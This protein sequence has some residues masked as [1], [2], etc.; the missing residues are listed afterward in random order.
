M[1]LKGKLGPY[2]SKIRNE[3]GEY[4]ILQIFEKTLDTSHPDQGEIPIE[5]LGFGEISI[6]FEI[7][8]E[9]LRG[10][11]FKRLPLFETE[12][13]VQRHIAAYKQ[14]REIL[15][16][17]IGLTIPPQ[18]TAWVYMDEDK[19]KIALYCIQDKIDPS[20]VINKKLSEISFPELQPILKRI[21]L[22]LKKVWQFNRENTE[23]LEVALDAQISNWAIIDQ[24]ERSSTEGFNNQET[25]STVTSNSPTNDSNSSGSEIV[26]L[27]TSTPLFRVDGEEAMEA[28][29]FMKSAPSFL[30]WMLKSLVQ[31]VVDRYYNIR[32][33]IIDLIANFYK[34]Q[35]ADLIP[36]VIEF[37]NSFLISEMEAYTI[38][39]IT[40][41]EVNKYY[42]HDKFIWVLYLNLRRFD[43]FLKTK[44][45]RKKYDFYLPEKIKR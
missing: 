15:T 41:K 36:M 32:D 39:P 8:T 26:Y 9:E 21:L 42:K 1:S 14:Y 30:R 10:L 6:V 17:K 45:F 28:S 24:P 4:E 19:K 18:D 3:S 44:I 22:E 2:L 20:S 40:E 43:R 16:A 25:S 12:E 35:R 33:V 7:L 38:T 27:D 5:L 31:E 34:E 37:V 23:Q 11:A 29:L 13:Q